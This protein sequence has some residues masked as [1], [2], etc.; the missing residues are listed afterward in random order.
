MSRLCSPENRGRITSY[1][2]VGGNI[3][4]ALGPI[5]A[6]VLLWWLGMP[7]LLLLVVPALII[8]GAL[9]YLLPAEKAE[10]C[11]PPATTPDTGQAGSDQKMPFFIL[12]LASTL[13]AWAIFAAITF[14][15]MYLVTQG[16][17]LV[18]A[19]TLVTLM[20]LSGVA[21]QIFGGHT[22]DRYGRKEFMVIGLLAAIPSFFLFFF[23]R[24]IVST[25]AMM[26]F[27]FALWST[28]SVAVAMSHELLPS[29]VGLASGVMLGFAIGVGGLGAA[30]NGMIADHYSPHLRSAPSRFQSL[31]RS[32]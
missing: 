15:P 13:R 24:G 20:L 10:E 27:G 8:A 23:T 4:Y 19:S 5:L 3:G 14:L 28:F 6:G 16:Y 29:N 7:G 25:I 32:C 1:F 9:R 2:V 21:G 31:L 12:L 11:P 22:S 30:I 26:L 17:S 18:A